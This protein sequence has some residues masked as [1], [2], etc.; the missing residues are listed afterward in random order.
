MAR[1]ATVRTFDIELSD[2]DRSVYET[3]A[4]KVAQHPSETAPYMVTR[5][6]AY[7][8]ERRE[9]LAF[10]SGLSTADAPALWVHDLTDRLLAWIEIGTPDAARLHK[11]SKAADRVAVYCHKEPS[12]WLRAIAGERVHAS[13]AI[14][15]Y[16]LPRALIQS[17]AD[18]VER[19]NTWSLTRMEQ[20][21]YLEVGS[22]SFEIPVERL[23][24]PS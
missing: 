5:V 22:E 4:L 23:G 14:E 18:V 21:I 12:G 3:L 15:L 16:A 2:V 9:G 20:V 7:A 11:A 24:W 1:G 10:S 8:L 13:G 6:L 19:R 17:L